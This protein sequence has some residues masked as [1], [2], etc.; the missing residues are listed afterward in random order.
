VTTIHTYINKMYKVTT[1]RRILNL[2]V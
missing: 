2:V 1:I